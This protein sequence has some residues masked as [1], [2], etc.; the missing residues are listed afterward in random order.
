MCLRRIGVGM[1]PDHCAVGG[2]KFDPGLIKSD[3]WSEAA[4]EFGHAVDTAGNHGSGEMVRAGDNVGHDFSIRGIWDR[5]FEDADDSGRSIA[6]AAEANGFTDDGRIALEN[7][8]PETIGQNDDAGGFRTVVLR[9]DETAEDGVKAHH[10]KIGAVNDAG[11]NFPGLAEA[12]HGET[13]GGELA[14]GAECFDACAQV[15]NFR[16]GEWNAPG[17]DTRRALLDENEALLVAV[18]ER[19]KEHATNQAEDGGV[20]ADA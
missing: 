17:A 12:D 14:E 15:M 18:D 9:S 11:A 2:S 6:E 1:V 3:A 7:G 16:H 4:E 19:P 20:G 13:D 10:V 5:G 8:G